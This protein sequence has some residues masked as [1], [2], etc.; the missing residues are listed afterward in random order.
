[1][2]GITRHGLVVCPVEEH[3]ASVGRA[4]PKRGVGTQAT[5]AVPDEVDDVCGN[6]VLLHAPVIEPPLADLRD[7]AD[8]HLGVQRR[9]GGIEVRTLELSGDD[10]L[11]ARCDV[12]HD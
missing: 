4:H 12:A 8:E 2:A 6:L 10:V 1:M 3:L 7:E 9:P 11:D 5:L